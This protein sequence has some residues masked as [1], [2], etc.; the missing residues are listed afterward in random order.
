MGDPDKNGCCALLSRFSHAQV[1]LTPWT[2]AC[3][4]SLS[5]GFS[6]QQYQS[7]LPRPPP[8]DPPNPGIEPTSL[9]SPALSDE[10]LTSTIWETLKKRSLIQRQFL[11]TQDSISN[12]TEIADVADL[13]ALFPMLQ[14]FRNI[15]MWDSV[16]SFWR[17]PFTLWALFESKLKKSFTRTLKNSCLSS[18]QVFTASQ[19]PSYPAVLPLSARIQW[20]PALQRLAIIMHLRQPQQQQNKSHPEYID[21]TH[22]A[23][24]LIR[25]KGPLLDIT[26]S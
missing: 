19:Q 6:R 24:G 14:A 12:L 22:H 26:I 13:L 15:N 25:E 4:A 21:S 20:S 11:F 1:F 7:G 3:Q 17:T 9:M 18:P 2:I 16:M 5:M 8:G 10:F 23:N